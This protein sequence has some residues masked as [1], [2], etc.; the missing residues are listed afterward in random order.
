M[1]LHQPPAGE[2]CAEAG[3]V[4]LLLDDVVNMLPFAAIVLVGLVLVSFNDVRSFLLLEMDASLL[5]WVNYG[6]FYVI[7]V[8]F[9]SAL[10]QTLPVSFM[11][12]PLLSTNGIVT[13]CLH[14]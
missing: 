2:A 14:M 5:G 10:E 1:W 11:P 9:K 7:N 12:P 3:R 6:S 8:Q 13:Q 4:R